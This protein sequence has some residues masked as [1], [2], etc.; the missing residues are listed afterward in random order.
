MPL[1]WAAAA[2]ITSVVGTGV[3][4]VAQ[5]HAAEDQQKVQAAQSYEQ[6]QGETRRKV[7]EQRITAARIKQSAANVGAGGSSGEAGALGSLASQ[8]ATGAS[9]A[10]FAQQS[11]NQLGQIQTSLARSQSKAAGIQIAGSLMGGVA[12]YKQSQ[13]PPPKT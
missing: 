7:R 1:Y 5:K 2:V 8:F 13:I 12:S 10:Q 11:S 6:R 3:S 9:A 4:A